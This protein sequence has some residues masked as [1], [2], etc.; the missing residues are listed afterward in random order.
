MFR[1]SYFET[2]LPWG[3]PFV[4]GGVASP[5]KQRRQFE[6]EWSHHF[7]H[8]EETK[9]EETKREPVVPTLPPLAIAQTPR[10][11]RS[12]PPP[13][14]AVQSARRPPSSQASGEIPLARSARHQSVAA[15]AT[16]NPE[17]VVA[18][19]ARERLRDLSE[20]YVPTLPPKPPPRRK[21]VRSFSYRTL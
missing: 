13:A 21:V 19:W 14:P 5:M 12:E 20:F 17:S 4:P 18:K 10:P 3:K 6:E 11:P 1:P 2:H 8:P 16:L 15:I 9:R 7:L